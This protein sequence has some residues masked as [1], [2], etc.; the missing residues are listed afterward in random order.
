MVRAEILLDR[1]HFSCGAIDGNFGTNLQTTVAAYQHDRHMEQ[2]GKLDAATW[3]SLNSDNAPSLTNYTI[4]A[5]DEKGPFVSVPHDMMEQAELP[6]LGYAS[7]LDE[8]GER[9]HST[10]TLL[11][12]LNPNADFTM[13]GQQLLV[14]NV[15][16]MPPAGTAARVF[17][18]KNEKS[19]R[20]YDQ[21]GKLMAFYMATIG[22][23]HDPLPLG[24]WKVT[25]VQRN[26]EFHYDASLFWD[27]KDPDDR[28]TI[29]PG[30]RNP[31]GIAKVGISKPHYGIHGT[32]DASKIGH[33]F[34]HGCIRLANWDAWEL[35]S[36][37]QPGMPVILKE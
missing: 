16:T 5:D 1:A 11:K 32:P 26:P 9:F 2:T 19:V 4:T 6:Y 36:L 21:D 25:T 37:V 3:S 8:L 29:K 22:S 14:P 12:A 10:P 30:P 24:D 23:T 35:A 33:T 7:A 20:V 31:V 34:S 28:A 27:A 15:M 17:V 13:V 18:S